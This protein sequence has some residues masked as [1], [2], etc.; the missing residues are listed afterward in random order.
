MIEHL[1]G[2]GKGGAGGG[3]VRPGRPFAAAPSMPCFP[4]MTADVLTDRALNR[5]TLARQMLLERSPRRRPRDRRRPP[6]RA[7]GAEPARPL[8]GPV[9]APGRLR[10]RRRRPGR[11]GPAP[12]PDRG[13]AGDDPPGHRGRRPRAAAVIQP[14]LDAEIARHSEYAPH[15]ARRRH[16]PRRGLRPRVLAEQPATMT[17]LRAAIAERFPDVHPAA[18]AYAHPLSRA[19][20]AGPAPGRV[21]TQGPG[22]AHPGRRLAGPP[23]R[24]RA[25]PDGRCC[26]TW[27]RSG[28]P[29]WPT[30]PPGAGS[31]A[32]RGCS[33]AWPPACAPSPTSGAARSYDVP[34]GP[35]P[36]PRRRGARAV[37]A[38]VRQRAPVV[39]RP[40]PVRVRREPPASRAGPTRSRA[41]CWSTAGSGRS[42]PPCPGR[43]RVARPSPSPTTR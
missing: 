16:R 10:P 32:M 28:R 20:R 23:A 18:A 12:R 42:G 9:V 2:H 14:V 36:R 31:P 15:L 38:R 40:Q 17:R 39:R 34:D 5:A 4:A 43:R 8:P 7:A 3:T 21:G 11:R 29:P 6:R 33:T 26:A 41:A 19:A 37:P 30:S 1:F 24:H 22:H 13:H 25:A 35:A 27:R